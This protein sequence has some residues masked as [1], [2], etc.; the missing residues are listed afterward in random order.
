MRSG[1][2]E[3]HRQMAQEVLWELQLIPR[4]RIFRRLRLRE[5]YFDHLGQARN[6]DELEVLMERARRVRV[7]QN[8]GTERDS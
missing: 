4:W 8:T 3:A 7:A 2:A 6:H 5:R 1:L